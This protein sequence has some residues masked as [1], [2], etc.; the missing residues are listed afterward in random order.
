MRED[1][2]QCSLEQRVRRQL[3]R[4]CEAHQYRDHVKRCENSQ[5][6]ENQSANAGGKQTDG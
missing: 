2:N 6:G 1:G 3:R 4:K 5:R